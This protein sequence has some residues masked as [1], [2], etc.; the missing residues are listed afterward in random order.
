MI[1]VADGRMRRLRRFVES[2][3]AA[4]YRG[5][6]I[7]CDTTLIGHCLLVADRNKPTRFTD[8]LGKNSAVVG[9]QYTPA[10]WAM[11]DRRK[12]IVRL[13]LEIPYITTPYRIELGAEAH[14]ADVDRAG[15][16]RQLRFGPRLVVARV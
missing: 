16:I 5:V 10:L 15:D 14:P 7:S 6:G 3:Y 9:R 13:I 12:A 8:E 1:A 11:R 2:S 4:A